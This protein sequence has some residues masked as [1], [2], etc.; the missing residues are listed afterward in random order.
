MRFCL[1]N[2][3][4]IDEFLCILTDLVP[5]K[6]KN[7]VLRWSSGSTP[8]KI[9]VS[10]PD[11][12]PFFPRLKDPWLSRTRNEG[13]CLDIMI[14]LSQGDFQIGPRDVLEKAPLC[15]VAGPSYA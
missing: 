13:L 3:I 12:F 5:M 9:V 2:M 14:T 7:E 11:R 10:A 4:L 8:V 6:S 1:P 15:Q